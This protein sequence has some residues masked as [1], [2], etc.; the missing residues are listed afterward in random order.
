MKA[1]QL[2]IR[3]PDGK[4]LLEDI[5]LSVGEGESLLITGPSGSG[6]ST[7]LRT[8]AGLWPFAQGS[9]SL[10]KEG[11][12]LFV[13]QK[14][15]LPLGTL[16]EVLCY[17]SRELADDTV[18]YPV[19]RQCR[20]DHLEGRLEQM[21][22]WSH[23]FSLGE[24]QRI[25]FARILL[26]KP[27]FLFLDEATSALDEHLEAHLYGLLKTLPEMSLISV[28]HRSTIKQW[29]NKEKPLITAP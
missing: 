14:P 28:G 25:A 17:P 27:D 15:Y 20:L 2:T 5:S 22:S 12:M 4:I 10:P 19:L 18:I 7:L 8:L 9:L 24:Q 1:D 21:E 13:P 23:I 16:R 11:R 6:K 29:H 26:N 3:L